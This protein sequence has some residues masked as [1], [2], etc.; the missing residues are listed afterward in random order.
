MNQNFLT[1]LLRLSDIKEKGDVKKLVVRYILSLL[2][3]LIIGVGCGVVVEMAVGCDTYTCFN[4]SIWYIFTEKLGYFPFGHINLFVNLIL[5]AFMIA[6]RR[7]LIGFGTLF[8]MITV[9]YIIDL[10]HFVF[11]LC[12]IPG[13]ELGMALRIGLIVVALPVIAFGDALYIEADVGISPY[14]AV[15]FMLEKLTCGRFAF[16]TLRTFTDCF[17][18]VFGF[19]IGCTTGK[20]FELANVGTVL[21]ALFTGMLIVFWQK[22]LRGKTV[23]NAH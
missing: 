18:L 17:C 7:D 19:L 16:G 4:R 22:I 9:G 13:T 15:P 6:L 21:L 10:V 20:Q 8:N 5:F 3:V 14:D 23:Q 11:V 1:A 2:G 12:G